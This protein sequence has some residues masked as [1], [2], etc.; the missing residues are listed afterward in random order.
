MVPFLLLFAAVPAQPLELQ[1][2]DTVV[3]PVARGA[4][5]HVAD[6]AVLELRRLKD[7]ALLL[8]GL[9]RG[10]TRLWTTGVG[11]QNAAWTVSVT[12]SDIFARAAEART[13]AGPPAR[14]WIDRSHLRLDCDACD[15]AQK[16]RADQAYALVART[17]GH[18]VAARP[19]DVVLAAAA[20]ILGEQADETPGLTLEVTP[21]RRV[22]LQGEVRT[23]ADLRRLLR[24]REQWPE[25][26]LDVRLVGEAVQA[27]ARELARPSPDPEAGRD[28]PL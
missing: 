4:K 6:P 23:E 18:P 7:D 16:E 13:L 25:V 15:A 1:E 24:L 11:K 2:G 22:L 8:I 21:R 19:P 5:P 14:F 28:A 17:G 10:T 9:R 27:W 3:V 12:R 20:A 26:G